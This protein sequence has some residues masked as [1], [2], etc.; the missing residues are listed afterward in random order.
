MRAAPVEPGDLVID[1]GAGTGALTRPLCRYG[2]RVVAVE[3]DA[4]RA[5]HLRREL[6]A[7]SVRVVQVDLRLL[8]LPRRP[9]RVV[10][11]PPY[12]LTAETLHLLM[13][14]ERL[15]SADVV[16]QRGAAERVVASGVSA[17]HARRYRLS[18]GLSVPR[19]AFTPPPRVDSVVLQV[20][21]R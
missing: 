4:G 9:F 15:L 13:S 20:R 12:A 5:A 1:L 11:S 3:L 6:A 17:R 21:R 10:A 7:E 14:T 2:A 18:L 8:R 19:R 16:L